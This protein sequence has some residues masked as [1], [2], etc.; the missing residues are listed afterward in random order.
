M[1]VHVYLVP[2]ERSASSFSTVL[3]TSRSAFV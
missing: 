2:G 1:D 3:V